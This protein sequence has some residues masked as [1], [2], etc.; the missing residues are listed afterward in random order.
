MKMI[1]CRHGVARGLCMDCINHNLRIRAA[2]NKIREALKRADPSG[3]MDRKIR[4]A[5]RDWKPGAK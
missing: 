3:E 5:A 4:E 2:Q 1:V